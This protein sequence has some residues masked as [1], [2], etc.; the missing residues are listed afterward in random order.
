MLDLFQGIHG[1][2]GLLFRLPHVDTLQ[3]DDLGLIL[4]SV[5]VSVVAIM[6]F[7][8]GFAAKEV[9]CNIVLARRVIVSFVEGG[10]VI[11]IWSH[12][13]DAQ[14][15]STAVLP[16]IVHFHL[17]LE[18]RSALRLLIFTALVVP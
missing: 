11:H 7:L 16:F 3:L 9:I 15:I 2:L 6:L 1:D 8:L 5:M 17:F 12:L 10:R 13:G 18:L 4:E 14:M